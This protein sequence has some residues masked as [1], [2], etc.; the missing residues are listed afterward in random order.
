MGLE[1]HRDLAVDLRE[2][3][4]IPV[5]PDQEVARTAQAALDAARRHRLMGEKVPVLIDDRPERIVF[6][7]LA[8][9][10]VSGHL[11]ALH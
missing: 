5:Q 6:R 10:D 1:T 9:G 8:A 11:S 7:G 4:A 3:E 2:T